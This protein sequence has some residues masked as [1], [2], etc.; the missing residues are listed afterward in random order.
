MADLTSVEYLYRGVEQE[1]LLRELDQQAIEGSMQEV[2]R[3]SLNT[4][5]NTPPIGDDI[6]SLDWEL[7]IPNEEYITGGMTDAMI[8]THRFSGANNYA[9]VV[10][11][12]PTPFR[13]VQYDYDWFNQHV[14]VYDHVHSASEGEIR[15]NESG[16]PRGGSLYGS[17]DKAIF[18]NRPPE[19]QVRHWGTGTDLPSTTSG[20]RM[21]NEQEWVALQREVPIRGVIEGIVAW[22]DTTGV[23]VEY[24]KGKDMIPKDV[25]DWRAVAPQVYEKLREPLPEW[26]TFY[27]LVADFQLAKNNDFDGWKASQLDA[28][29]RDDGEIPPE[30]VPAKFRGAA[31]R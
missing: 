12:E 16:S 15:V 23:R 18:T 11:K 2:W 6:N 8:Q 26:T 24:S 25:D 4:Y 13:K 22:V 30:M 20:S 21:A 14:G 27:L 1:Q 10:E 29:F 9:M 3:G 31:N 7:L 28:A 17:V 5:P 19:Y